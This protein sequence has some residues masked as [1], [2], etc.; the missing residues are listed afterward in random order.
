MLLFDARDPDGRRAS[1]L[2][3]PPLQVPLTTL[4]P[5]SP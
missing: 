3:S 2:G 5:F 4:G 1:R